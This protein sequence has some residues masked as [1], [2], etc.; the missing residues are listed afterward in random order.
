MMEENNLD[1][2]TSQEISQLWG[3]YMGDSAQACILSYFLHITKDESIKIIVQD[4]Y[5]GA[6]EHLEIISALFKEENY[7]VPFGFSLDNDVTSSSNSELFSDSFILEF[8]HQF[9]RVGMRSH[10]VNLSLAV[11]KDTTDLFE[12]CLSDSIRLY[13]LVKNALIVKGL[14]IHSPF[15]EPAENADFIEE[16]GFLTG[17]FGDR[18]PLLSTEVT[19]LYAN[20]QRNALGASVMLGFSQVAKSK[21]ISKHF[22]RGKEIAE[23]HC[24]IFS[25]FLKEDHLPAGLY[26]D[27]QVTDTTEYVFSDKLM[28]YVAGSLTAMGIGFYGLGLGASM[29]RDIAAAYNR[30]LMEIQLYAEDGMNIMIKHKWLESPPKAVRHK[31]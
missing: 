14:Y 11:R 31:K 30:L 19:N 10:A 18:R 4:A 3:T 23:K 24:E 8:L 21:E 28:M 17:I 20:F 25:T 26:W 9:G 7:P 13:N 12:K 1:R 16:Q 2:L 22:I 27:S 15:L 6:L 5:Q 29:R